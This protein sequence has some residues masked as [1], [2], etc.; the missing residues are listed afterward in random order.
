MSE[1]LVNEVSLFFYFFVCLFIYINF[2]QSKNSNSTNPA[3]SKNKEKFLAKKEKNNFPI[4]PWNYFM[5]K[6][7]TVFCPYPH[8]IKN[9]VQFKK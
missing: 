8:I 1:V 9:N 5:D 4:V 6:I 7:T 3:S 2:L